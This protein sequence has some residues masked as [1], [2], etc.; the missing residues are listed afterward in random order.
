[1]VRKDGVKKFAREP[2]PQ[3]QLARGDVNRVTET[4]SMPKSGETE[5]WSNEWAART[6][7]Y[8]MHARCRE[9]NV[10]KEREKVKSEKERET[11][12]KRQGD[13]S[14]DRA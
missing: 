6:D 9:M 13:R 14:K 10:K 8:S 4:A 3:R 5:T 12:G 2:S 11:E 1:M 7:S